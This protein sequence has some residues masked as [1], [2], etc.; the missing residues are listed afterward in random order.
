M[1]YNNYFPATYQP[2][3]QQPMYQ[4][5]QPQIQQTAQPSSLMWVGSY[6]E[7][8]AYPVAP[9]NAVAL[10]DSSSPAIYLKQA[11]ASGRPTLKVFDIVERT[12]SVSPKDGK[13]AD[14]ATKDDLAAFGASLEAIKGDIETMKGDIYGLAGKK[15]VK[16]EVTDDE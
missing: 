3:Y 12:E 15:R 6:A 2:M 4:Q 8:Q 14:Y 11:D 16:K 13:V 5:I 7:A 9:N 1:A 10:W